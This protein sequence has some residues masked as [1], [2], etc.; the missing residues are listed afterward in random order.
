MSILRLLA[1]RLSPF[2]SLSLS[3]S[4]LVPEAPLERLWFRGRFTDELLLLELGVIL[5]WLEALDSGRGGR[6][7]DLL[8][9]WLLSS[10]AV[11]EGSRRSLTRRPRRRGAVKKFV[12]ELRSVVYEV[13]SRGALRRR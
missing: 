8:E 13:S 7:L 11:E 3:C 10:M 1:I 9:I 12:C 2:L 6:G 4:K 5:V